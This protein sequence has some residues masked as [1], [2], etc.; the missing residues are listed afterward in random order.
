MTGD[1]IKKS[2]NR[3]RLARNHYK[4]L[5]SNH[6]CYSIDS[7]VENLAVQFND[8]FGRSMDR[9]DID[10]IVELIEEKLNNQ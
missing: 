10:M 7:S 8:C 2:M 4:S 5:L 9:I 3:A 6:L 1:E